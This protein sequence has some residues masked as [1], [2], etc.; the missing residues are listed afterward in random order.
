MLKKNM[1]M[2][3]KQKMDLAVADVKLI[4]VYVPFF[5]W[6]NTSDRPEMCQKFV[7]IWWGKKKK[8]CYFTVTNITDSGVT[9]NSQQTAD[10]LSQ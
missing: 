7:M 8:Y 1:M 5:S 2:K 6:L 10:E 9:I 4:S 3:P